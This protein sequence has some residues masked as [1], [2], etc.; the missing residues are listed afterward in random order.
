MSAARRPEL[1][2]SSANDEAVALTTWLT[3]LGWQVQIEQDGN[4]YVG[5]ARHFTPGGHKLAVGACAATKCES[6]WQLFEAVM[7]RLAADNT[8]GETLRRPAARSRLL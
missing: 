3:M 4:L 6:V 5:V 1:V 7:G 8:S 2:Q